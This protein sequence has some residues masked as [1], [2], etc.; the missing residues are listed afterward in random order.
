MEITELYSQFL[1]SV[2]A[3][4]PS[5][6][7]K[8]IYLS[9]NQVA[10][11]YQ[12]TELGIGESLLI[13]A[14]ADSTQSSKQHIKNLYHEKGDLGT[15]A[16]ECRSSQ[17]TMF[18]PKALT[19]Q[20]VFDTFF[21]IASMKGHSST[22]RKVDKIKALLVCCQ[23]C[24]S[25][26]IIR[27]LGG[28]LRIGLAGQTVLIAIAH[29]FVLTPPRVINSLNYEEEKENNFVEILDTAKKLSESQLQAHLLRAEAIVKQVHSQ[30]PTFDLII[31]QLLAGN[32]LSVC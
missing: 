1:R 5:D 29:A 7:L 20:K 19:V 22:A 9:I 2:I 28:K 32:L 23:E 4:T 8:V 30:L 24:E 15:V 6:L 17:K 10:P 25:T 16:Q 21:E 14:I 18:K 27:S 13:K 26:Y 31:P 11:A 12:S 3:T